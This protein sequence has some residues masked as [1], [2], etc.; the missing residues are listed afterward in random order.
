MP[1]VDVREVRMLVRQRLVTVPVLVRIVATPLEVMFM[2]VMRVV[3]VA[4]TVC[5]RFMHMLVLMVLR[6]V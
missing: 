3:D 6:E 4:M 1:V 2:P 5:Q